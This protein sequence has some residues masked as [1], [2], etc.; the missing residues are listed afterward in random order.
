ML[1][2]TDFMEI[3]I[4]WYDNSD[5]KTISQILGDQTIEEWQGKNKI[6]I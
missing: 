1:T 3:L 5:K 2:V 4:H 6:N